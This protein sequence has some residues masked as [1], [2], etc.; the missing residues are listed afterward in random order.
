MTS[1]S[2][3][4]RESYFYY[5]SETMK[6]IGQ[7]NG[8]QSQSSVTVSS[9]SPSVALSKQFRDPVTPQHDPEISLSHRQCTLITSLNCSNLLEQWSRDGQDIPCVM[10]SETATCTG[11]ELARSKFD[12]GDLEK[13][14]SILQGLELDFNYTSEEFETGLRKYDNYTIEDLLQATNDEKSGNVQL[15]DIVY[16]DSTVAYQRAVEYGRS[17]LVQKSMCKHYVYESFQFQDN[18][19]VL[20]IKDAARWAEQTFDIPNLRKLWLKRDNATLPEVKGAKIYFLEAEENSIS[21]AWPDLQRAIRSITQKIPRHGMMEHSYEQE[22]DDFTS[23]GLLPGRMERLSFFISIALLDNEGG[24]L[25]D[26]LVPKSIANGV[27]FVITEVIVENILT[28][29]LV[30]IPLVLNFYD[31]PTAGSNKGA[32]IQDLTTVSADM[33]SFI[34]SFL[35]NSTH[36]SLSIAQVTIEARRILLPSSSDVLAKFDIQLCNS[37]AEES[38]GGEISICV[39]DELFDLDDEYLESPK[40]QDLMRQKVYNFIEYHRH[41]GHI[42]RFYFYGYTNFTYDMLADYIDKK[43]VVYTHFPYIIDIGDG[44]RRL[45]LERVRSIFSAKTRDDVKIS[46]RPNNEILELN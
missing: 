23:N 34:E 24:H 19:K 21:A 42:N 43:I 14:Y 28:P 1:D 13:S 7:K 6:S 44:N 30:E 12:D 45:G 17:R 22:D 9:Q 8:S 2:L 27:A 38:D 32:I 33:T 37:P 39:M 31:A 18:D 3:Q 15:G 36:H 46:V 25:S 26:I 16:R 35:M 41:V 10:D 40:T 29:Y 5:H 11:I 20:D 4:R